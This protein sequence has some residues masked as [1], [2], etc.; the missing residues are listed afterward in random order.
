[1]ELIATLLLFLSLFFFFGLIAYPLLAFLKAYFSSNKVDKSEA[2]LAPVSIIISCYNEEDFIRDKINSLIDDAEWIQGSE[3][4]IFSGGSTDKTHEILNEFAQN[5]RLVVLISTERLSKIE[6]VNRAVAIAKNEFLVFSDCR[7]PI[8]KGSIKNLIH[9][10]ND[11]QVG[12]VAAS[13]LDT[14]HGNRPSFFRSL[15]NFI[16]L[17][18]SRYS[19]CLN[20]YGALYA[21]RKTVFRLIPNDLLF[22]DL[23]V[24]VSTLSQGKRLIQ[25]KEAIIYDVNFTNYYQPERIGRLVRGLLIFL[26]NHYR[27]I[28]SLPNGP[29]I[30]FLYFKYLKLMMPFFL[31]SFLIGSSILLV[32]HADLKIG[33][34][35]LVFILIGFLIGSVRRF[36]GLFIKINYYFLGAIWSYYFNAKRSNKWEKL[37]LETRNEDS[38]TL[39]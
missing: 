34:G 24:V 12:T 14:K 9:N 16:S 39:L 19:S 7:Q 20:V 36:M 4:I 29:F 11:P 23:F 18:E 31:I 8:K 35:L 10:F 21:Q 30:R 26:F 33:L 6:G 3:L 37:Q 17:K 27:L 13:L 1:M 5:D 22:D 2:F 32:F 15:F 25:D 38:S 28:R